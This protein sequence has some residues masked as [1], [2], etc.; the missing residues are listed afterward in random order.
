MIPIICPDELYFM[1]KWPSHYKKLT[2][3]ALMSL[4]IAGKT[5]SIKELYNRYSNKLLFYFYRM[6]SG[7]EAK[8]Q[9]FL[10]DIFLKI[11]E[12]PEQFNPELKF[13]T[14]IFS[15]ASNLCKNE[16]RRLKV[17]EIVENE[18]NLDRY[19]RD[20]QDYESKIDHNILEMAI[21]KI[22]M[23]LDT[24]QR[25]TFLLRFQENYSIDEISKV[26]SCAP[27]TVKS[28]LFYTSRK[29]ALCLKDF[30]PYP[31]KEK[32]NE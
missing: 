10:Q 14:W 1:M 15:I 8:A 28:R 2:D 16:Y 4:V 5:A 22:L 12:K 26:L 32:S 9:D 23:Q 20:D 27:G 19:R 3:E 13:S 6:L 17:R 31:L 29:L 11:L 30:N 25:S 7:N 21:Q 18:S 24:D